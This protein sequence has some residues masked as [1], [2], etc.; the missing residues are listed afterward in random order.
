VRRDFSWHAV[1]AQTAL[2]Y[3]EAG[4]TSSGGP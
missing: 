2:V 3:D 1:A 4:L